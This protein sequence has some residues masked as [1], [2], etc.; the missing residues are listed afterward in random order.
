MKIFIFSILLIAQV[1]FAQTKNYSVSKVAAES[2]IYAFLKSEGIPTYCANSYAN[3]IFKDGGII[4]HGVALENPRIEITR[5]IV[6]KTEGPFWYAN[7]PVSLGKVQFV[8][9]TKVTASNAGYS[10]QDNFHVA[11]LCEADF[12]FG[13]W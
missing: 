7:N 6:S 11:V 1:V 5:Q 3:V 13:D 10:K 12:P 8:L 2:D 4:A 9:Q